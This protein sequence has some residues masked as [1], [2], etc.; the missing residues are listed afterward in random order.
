MPDKYKPHEPDKAYF[1]TMATVGW[2]DVF[3]RKY[4]KLNIV[5]SLKH[6]QEEKGLR[7]FAMGIE[8]TNEINM[9]R[10]KY[11]PKE[12]K[13]LFIAEAP[14]SSQD[15]FFYFEKVYEQDS[16]YLE[17]MRALIKPEPKALGEMGGQT[18][19]W[20]GEIPVDVLRSQKESYLEQFKERGY[21]LI[22][23]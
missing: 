8:H 11:R 17:L 2:V 22:D 1:I 3:T 5:N 10:E 13:C 18:F 21:Y 19:Y 9:A 14:P 16:L 12:I 7:I 20:E 6:C 15:R 4:L 23:S